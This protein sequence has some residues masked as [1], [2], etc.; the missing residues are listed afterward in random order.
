MERSGQSTASDLLSAAL[1]QAA[2]GGMDPLKVRL[3]LA[4][5]LGVSVPELL[6][7]KDGSLSSESVRL[8]WQ[9]YDRLLHNEPLQYILGHTDFFGLALLTDARA[10]IPRPETEGL[11][12]WVLTETY[13]TASVLEIGTGSGAIAIAIKYQRPAW[14]ICVTDSSG[15]ALSLAMANAQRLQVEINFLCCD[16][17]PH[18]AD[19]YDL[20]VSNPPYVAQSGYAVLPDEI[21]LYEPRAALVSDQEGTGHLQ[22]IINGAINRLHPDGSLYLE[23]G[24]TQSEGLLKYAQEA[25]YQDIRIRQDLA[26]R[27]RYLRLRLT[28]KG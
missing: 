5:I 27:D 10:L 9:Y 8:F 21:R 7:H 19:R 3:L 1:N 16:L 11:V 14:Q 20:I 12:E 15:E 18:S 25:G 26:G 17:F 13:E 6:L 4:D 24:E 28:G 22:R 23:I 2:A